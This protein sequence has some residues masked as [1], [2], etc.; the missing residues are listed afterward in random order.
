MGIVILCIMAWMVIGIASYAYWWTSENDLTA[1]DLL[2]G[3][4]FF[5]WV[6][7]FAFITGAAI[8]SKRILIRRR[9]AK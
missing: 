1:G 9:R 7:P 2:T 3:L 8:Y 6:G 4:I 5:S